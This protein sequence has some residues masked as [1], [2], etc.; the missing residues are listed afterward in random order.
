MKTCKICG[1]EIDNGDN[2]ICE[3]CERVFDLKS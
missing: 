3:M 1:R 2:D